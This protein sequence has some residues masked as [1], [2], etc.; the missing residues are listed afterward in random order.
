MYIEYRFFTANKWNNH[1]NWNWLYSI[2]YFVYFWENSFYHSSTRQTYFANN[3][4]ISWI[5]YIEVFRVLDIRINDNWNR[6]SLLSIIFFCKLD[7]SS[8][9]FALRPIRK[10]AIL[11]IVVFRVVF[12]QIFL[13]SFIPYLFEF[14]YFLYLSL[15]RFLSSDTIFCRFY[16]IY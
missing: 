3:N 8:G 5:K 10:L 11:F 4:E 13:Y 6:W 1:I 7:L 9:Y 12:Y 16:L 14:M 2:V 15:F